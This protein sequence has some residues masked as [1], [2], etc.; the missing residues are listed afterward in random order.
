[1]SLEATVSGTALPGPN[2]ERS[3]RNRRR[4]KYRAIKNP[5]K[6]PIATPTP[7]AARS[8]SD[9]DRPGTLS[10]KTSTAALIK[11][12]ARAVIRGHFTWRKRSCVRTPNANHAKKCTNLSKKG[13]SDGGENPDVSDPARTRRQELAHRSAR[14][15]MR[16]ARRDTKTSVSL[17]AFKY[18]SNT[19]G[20]EL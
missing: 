18:N 19:L 15:L 16:R 8:Q 2:P 6:I 11:T 12:S 5:N 14:S 20:C 17:R 4:V 10:C 9:A 7:F 1:M 13:K 3:C